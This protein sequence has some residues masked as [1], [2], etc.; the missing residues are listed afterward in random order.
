MAEI[1]SIAVF[2]PL[3]GKEQE[4]LDTLRGLIGLLAERKYSRDL[5]Y[6]DRASR[7]FLDVRY[8][9]SE[10]ARQ[11]AHD[12]PQVHTYWARLGNLIRIEHVYETFDPVEF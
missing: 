8:W 9:S 6:R 2:E 5:V 3:E 4:A 7:R 10:S 1:F 12:D 11:D